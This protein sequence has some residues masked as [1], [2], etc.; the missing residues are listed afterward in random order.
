M[1]CASMAAP[2]GEA[3]VG[4]PTRARSTRRVRGLAGPA[5]G[6]AAG[7]GRTRQVVRA[8]PP[9]GTVPAR[10]STSNPGTG[11][12]SPARWA[13]TVWNGPA[14][15]R[16]T[17][18][19]DPD[20]ADD[21]LA[22]FAEQTDL[23]RA[24]GPDVGAARGGGDEGE[25]WEGRVVVGADEDGEPA[26]QLAPGRVAL[27]PLDDLD[28]PG[29]V[30]DGGAGGDEED[31]PRRAADDPV[32]PGGRRQAS[33]GEVHDALPRASRASASSAAVRYRAE[34]SLSKQRRMIS[35]SGSDSPG[36]SIGGD[37]STRRTASS[38]SRSGRS[39]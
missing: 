15:S 5:S 13:T 3:A 25:A 6:R 1:S 23:D 39:P 7:A 19:S 17:P 20:G 28:Q 32:G 4:S 38:G 2:I 30:V 8:K 22:T 35:A 37:D 33:V 36:S 9:A 27:R 26:G 12:G 24:V 14:T 10:R 29:H 31:R 18:V 11:T 16:S 34:R 21:L